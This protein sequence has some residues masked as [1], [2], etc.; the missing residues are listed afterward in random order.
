MSD[1]KAKKPYSQAKTQMTR[2]YNCF[3]YNADILPLLLKVISTHR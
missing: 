2:Q 3:I 1:V